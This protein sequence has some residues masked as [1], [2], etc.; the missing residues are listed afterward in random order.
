MRE[1]HVIE[2][3]DGDNGYKVIGTIERTPQM[4]AGWQSVTWRG[5]RYQL[6]GGIRNPEFINVRH[7]LNVD[8]GVPANRRIAEDK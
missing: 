5:Q 4:H 6:H 2:L 8:P 3:K 1:K 7:P